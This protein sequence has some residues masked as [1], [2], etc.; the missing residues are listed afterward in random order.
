MAQ[1]IQ[2]EVL[3]HILQHDSFVRA[4][5]LHVDVERFDDPLA[6]KIFD[7]VV[8]FF[9]KYEKVPRLATIQ[10]KFPKAEITLDVEEPIAYYVEQLQSLYFRKHSAEFFAKYAALLAGTG[11]PQEVML[12]MSQEVF[13]TFG[14]INVD[15]FFDT[16]LSAKEQYADYERVESGE[17]VG[18]MTPFDALNKMTFGYQ[19]GDY[20]VISARPGV[21]KCAAGDSKIVVPETGEYISLEAAYHRQIHTVLSLNEKNQQVWAPVTDYL[22]DG[23]REV[24]EIT[25]R[26]GRVICVTHEH[27]LLT[28]QGWCAAKELSSQDSIAVPTRIDVEGKIEKSQAELD[29]LAL[30]LADGSCTAKTPAYHKRDKMLVRLFKKSAREFGFRRINKIYDHGIL[31]GHRA[32]DGPEPMARFLARHELACLSREKKIPQFVWT[33]PNPQLAR[34]LGVLFSGDGYV[35]KMGFEFGVAS[36]ELAY[37]VIHALLRLGIFARIRYKRT[38]F[39]T[40]AWV[41]HI[42]DSKNL[43]RLRDLI[44]LFGK[45]KQQLRKLAIAIHSAPNVGGF[46]VDQYP[47]L[48]E[49]IPKSSPPKSITGQPSCGL[50]HDGTRRV[51]MSALRRWND[52]D[53]E[54]GT[55]SRWLTSEDVLWDDIA[56]IKKRALLTR[57]FDLSVA[58]HH[59]FIANDVYLHNTFLM[60]YLAWKARDEGKNVVFVTKEMTERELKLR[61]NAM[62]FKLPFEAYRGGMLTAKQKKRLRLRLIQRKHRTE[63]G[64]TGRLVILDGSG[65]SLATLA[66]EIQGEHPDIV[67]WDGLYLVDDGK[68]RGEKHERIGNIS[69]G[70][71]DLALRLKLPFVVSSQIHRMPKGQ[72]GKALTDPTIDDLAFSDAFGQDATLV[73]TLRADF[74]AKVMYVGTAKSRN[75]RAIDWRIRWDIDTMQDFGLEMPA[76]GDL[77]E[78]DD[79]IAVDMQNIHAKPTLDDDEDN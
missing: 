9:E 36:K 33:S 4:R 31:V 58:L 26:S 76:E 59:N 67:F 21:G 57:V 49:C 61:L 28:P 47:K 45:R 5:A 34:F 63:S 50:I 8:R 65:K 54:N 41:V 46:N 6:K 10:K 73:L 20:I 24:L 74:A 18:I 51:K 1:N 55:I 60:L 15:S 39:D 19:P 27:P 7:F 12:R 70:V 25:T 72:N 14:K 52:V 22:D 23:L 69:R 30:M 62:E 68:G 77:P 71:R 64:D 37:D 78:T 79:A 48:R 56:H 75:S 38:N 17:I 53:H 29:L 11:V 40:D 3:S 13:E 66:A 2:W 35:G 44:P 32:S 42:H 43:R 16:G